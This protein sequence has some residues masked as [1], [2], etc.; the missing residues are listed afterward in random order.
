MEKNINIQQAILILLLKEQGLKNPQNIININ[1]LATVKM[2]LLIFLKL[3]QYGLAFKYGIIF[4]V[5]IQNWTQN[6]A[7]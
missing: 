5:R 7:L 4:Q 1:Y 6:C 2:K 3:S